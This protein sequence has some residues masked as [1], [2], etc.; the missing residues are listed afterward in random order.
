MPAEE[1]FRTIT[2]ASK[3]VLE[4]DMGIVPEICKLRVANLRKALEAILGSVQ[5]HLQLN[6]MAVTPHSNKVRAAPL[7]TINNGR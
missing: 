6:F 2:A 4:Y 5:Q 3:A 1:Y 7:Q